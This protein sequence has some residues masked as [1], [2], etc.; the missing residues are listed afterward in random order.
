MDF[1]LGKKKKDFAP[2]LMPYIKINFRWLKDA[3]LK[4]KT[5]YYKKI[6]QFLSF[7]SEQRRAL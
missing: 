7:I 3:N 5:K 6:C 4:M 1:L 2:D